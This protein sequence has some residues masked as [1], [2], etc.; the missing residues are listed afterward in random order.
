M[1]EIVLVVGMS[2]LVLCNLLIFLWFSR[3]QRRINEKLNHPLIEMKPQPPP[4]VNINLKPLE[5][6]IYNIPGKVLHSIQSSINN[7]KGKLGELIGYLELEAMYDRIL[8][9]GSIVDFI[10]VQFPENSRPGTVDFIDIKTGKCARLSKDQKVLQRL[11]KEK[12]INFKKI[13]ISISDE[14]IS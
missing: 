2:M 1:L 4:Q 11:I 12:K 6:A 5:N 9:V 3:N 7:K 10:C 13:D 8:P 14:A